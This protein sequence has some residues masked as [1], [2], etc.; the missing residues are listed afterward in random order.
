[1][2]RRRLSNFT[3]LAIALWTL[4]LVS[5]LVWNIRQEYANFRQQAVTTARA[6][7][8]KDQAVR[9]WASQKGGIYVTPSER[10]PPS[11]YMA[12]LP[13]RDLTAQNGRKLTLMNP[14]YMM[15]EIMED[16][17]SLYGIKG[18]IVGI[19]ALNPKNRA[20]PWEEKAILAFSA[21]ATEV[22]EESLV[23]GRPYLRLIRPM[24]M[25]EDCMKCHGHLNFKVGDV[26]GGVGVSIP[27]ETY[28][29][30]AYDRAATL[31]ATHGGIWFIGLAGIG[32]VS[33]RTRLWLEEREKDVD[34]LRLSACAFNDGLQAVMITDPDGRILRVNQRFSDITG[35]VSDEAVGLTPAIL[36]SGR[37]DSRFYAGFWQSLKQTGRWEGEFWNRKKSGDLFAVLESVSAVRDENGK[38]RY[39]V[40][41]FQDITERKR[42]QETIMHAYG[43]NRAITEAIHDSLYMTDPQG[44]LMWWNKRFEQVTG[45]SRADLS[46]M[47]SPDIFVAEDRVLAANG[48][49]DVLD[50]GYAEI[51]ARL[52]TPAGPVYYQFNGVRIR[53][54]DG[55]VAGIAGVGR[56]ISE[57]RQTEERF[58]LLNL[59]LEDRVEARTAELAQAK[60]QAET[61]NRSKSEFLS[62]MSH[63]LRT[64]MNAILGFSQLLELSRNLDPEEKRHVDEILKGGKHLLELI[65]EVLDLARIEAGR[66]DLH[67]VPVDCRDVTDECASLMEPLLMRFGISLKVEYQAAEQ[68]CVSAD[69]TRL[70]Q[71]LLNLLSNAIKYNR[72]DGSVTVRVMPAGPGG[73]RWEVQDTGQGIPPDRQNEIFQSFHRLGA[74][75]F[76]VEGTGIGLVISKNVVEAMGG[77]IGFISTYGVGSVFW[78]EMPRAP[79]DTNHPGRDPAGTTAHSAPAPVIPK[80]HTLLYVEDNPAN[81]R[82]ME[83][84]VSRLPDYRLLTA[85][86]AEDGLVLARTHLP[87]L[88]LMDINLPGMSGYEAMKKL[89][90]TEET[91]HIRVLALS[92]F[93]MSEDSAKG[94]AAGFHDYITK[95]IDIERLSTAIRMALFDVS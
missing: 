13:D 11:P 1:M 45:L 49:R 38:V 52:I 77:V 85:A 79:G 9:L 88:I 87:D 91:R 60:L 69:R 34:E 86:N 37:H 29:A 71:A 21:G 93:A 58:R 22:M 75:R 42:D 63:E 43:E 84:I 39:F 62:S 81:V 83:S 94:K 78:I 92:A 95:P 51:E 65:N 16:Y 27:L 4:A 76:E 53:D 6:N 89:R 15:R 17:A 28:N 46:G 56:D 44:R 48:I 73:M 50:T 80:R 59:E 57:R 3:W 14:N 20:D 70:K 35:Y 54:E 72:P 24:I 31:A 55:N 41:M 8:F 10:T 5:V 90:E 33:R 47:A 68:I 12:H 7:F 61:A 82:L 25:T 18:R 26:R 19:V 74:D 67:I 23:D 32:L 36:K 66:M 40:S 2:I 64:P 30:A